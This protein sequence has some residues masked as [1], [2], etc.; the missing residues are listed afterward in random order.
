MGSC[1][2]IYIYISLSLSLSPLSHY[3]GLA[4]PS[5]PSGHATEGLSGVFEGQELAHVLLHRFLGKEEQVLAG[6]S[7]FFVGLSLTEVMSLNQALTRR[8]SGA[9]H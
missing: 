7:S 8:A 3:E 1:I 5:G 4:V 6:T 9:E 2:Y